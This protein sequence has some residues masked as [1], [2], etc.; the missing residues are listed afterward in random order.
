MTLMGQKRSV[1]DHYPLVL[2]LETMNNW[3]PKPFRTYDAWFLNPKFK[4]FI[5]NEWINLPDVSPYNKFKVFKGPL[6]DWSKSHY[7]QLDN[8]IIELESVIH[9]LEKLSDCRNL[10]VVEKARLSA[11]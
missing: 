4:S 3:G 2:S 11:A 10:T 7:A 5:R 8:R 9:D 1:F 6:R